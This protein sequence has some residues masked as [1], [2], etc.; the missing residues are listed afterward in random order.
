MRARITPVV[1]AVLALAGG[2]HATRGADA[3]GSV[4]ISARPLIAL[5]P[6]SPRYEPLVLAGSIPT[7]T[8]GR[9]VTIQANECSYPGWRDVTRARTDAGGRWHVAFDAASGM[10][11]TKTTFRARWRRAVSRP[12]VVLARP[13]VE[14]EQMRR[15]RWGVSLRALRSFLGRKGHLQRFDREDRRWRTIKTFRF[16]EK[17][18]LP[19]GAQ[20]A[21][22]V[23]SEARFRKAV[24]RGEQ[25]RVHVPRSQ[26]RPCYLA[27]YSPIE[28]VR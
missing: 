22:G 14:L 25:V 21:A 13:G 6:Q 10:G 28:T 18:T 1:V 2:L 7:Q 27:A 11:L 15:M 9:T 19:P 8:A 20:T 17:L 24:A 16:T 4:T 23:W 26:L 3:S 12:V 5:A